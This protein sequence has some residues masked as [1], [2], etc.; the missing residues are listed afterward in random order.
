MCVRRMLYAHM[1]KIYFVFYDV[2]CC[3]LCSTAVQVT[4]RDII[5]LLDGSLNVG[6]ANFPFV[7]DFVVTLVNYLD[8][9][10]DKIRVGLVQFS[11]TPKTEFFLYSYQT[12]SDIIQRMGQL[13]PKGGSVLNTGSALNFVFSNHFTEAGGSR[14]NEQVPQVLVLVTAGKS[15]DPFLQV[16]NELARAGVLTFAVGVRNADK[17]ELEQIAFNPRM[18]YFM[19]DFSDLTALPQELNKPITTYVSG[20]VEEVPLAPTGNI[21]LPS[22]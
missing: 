4:K 14:I 15:A 12:K 6:N 1:K 22:C 19:D 20:G 11:D 18:V 8:V 13:R 21:Y 16:S 9:G 2:S 17:A 10:S 7:R 5:F 3:F